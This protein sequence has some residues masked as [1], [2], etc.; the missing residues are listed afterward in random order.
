MNSISCFPSLVSKSRRN[1]VSQD[2]ASDMLAGWSK[3]S[4]TLAL[5]SGVIWP[6]NSNVLVVKFLRIRLSLLAV[7][8]FAF[9][10]T[11]TNG[12]GEVRSLHRMT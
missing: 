11:F 4:M 3:I 12:I 6:I 1:T 8:K 9:S 5:S 2:G 10:V 7:R